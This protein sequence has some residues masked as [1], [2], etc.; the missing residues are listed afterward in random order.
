MKPIA[1]NFRTVDSRIYRSNTGAFPIVLFEFILTELLTQEV[2]SFRLDSSAFCYK[3]T[4]GLP[5]KS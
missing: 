1:R 3:I 5:T 4:K 2:S